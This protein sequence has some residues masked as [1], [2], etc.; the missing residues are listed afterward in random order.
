MNRSLVGALRRH[1][2]RSR[3]ADD[4]IALVMTVMIIL[5]I[6]AL[7]AT[8]AYISVGN[9]R[10]AN[11][12]RQG[13]GAL[14]YADAGVAAAV[15]YLRTHPFS[16]I[17]CPQS[18]VTPGTTPTDPNCIGASVVSWSNPLSPQ[19]VSSG[20]RTFKVWISLVAPASLPSIKFWTFRVHSVGVATSNVQATRVI[21]VD[22]KAT[23]IPLPIGVYANY[24]D[25]TG[26]G[27]VTN[28]SIMSPN[29]INANGS[30]GSSGTDLFY[31]GVASI[32]SATGI[33][34]NGSCGNGSKDLVSGTSCSI[35]S[36]ALSDPFGTKGTDCYFDNSTLSGY[37]YQPGGLIAA[38]WAALKTMAVSEGQYYNGTASYTPPDPT[39]YPNAV[40]FF[41]NPGSQGVTLAADLNAYGYGYCG[42]RSL[43]I[44]VR[45]GDVTMNQNAN[46][47]GAIIAPQGSFKF[48]GS[49]TFTGTVFADSFQ[50]FNGTSTLQMQN[51]WLANPPGGLMDFTQSNYRQV[52]R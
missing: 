22:V 29:C 10:S 46:I 43:I 6:T 15:D 5:V 44:V 27:T 18:S 30:F 31:T 41:D 2:D 45:N 33:V 24:V 14:D 47:T 21:E 35:S 4:G 51:C 39:V 32:K 1:L 16:T 13:Q 12:D 36:V 26:N 7:A 42:T 8:M 48:N 19:V 50:K 37:G 23:P 25:A 9:L 20:N 38:Q 52:D 11:A 49:A 3:T 17:T 28:E 34:K 40:M